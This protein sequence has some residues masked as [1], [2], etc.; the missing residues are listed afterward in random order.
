MESVGI[1]RALWRR[2]LLV[3][4][5]A[6]LA[7]AMA[8]F[9][10]YRVSPASL[11]LQARTASSGYALERVLIDTP[12]SLAADAD[13]KG[14]DSIANRAALLGAL[15]ASDEARATMADKLGLRPSQ[16]A[17]IGAAD[18]LPQVPTPLA[19]KAIEVA[20]PHE[21]YSVVVDADPSLP[22]LS[23]YAAAPDARKAE[24]L[25]DQAIAA[26]HPLAAATLP[27]AGDVK[28]ERLGRVEAGTKT[29]SPSKAKALAVGLMVFLIWCIAIIVLDSLLLRR[30]ALPPLMEARRA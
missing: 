18:A 19:T 8:V 9:A 16:I 26:L 11:S 10:V 7:L 20:K 17:V 23:I 5:G 6:L 14:A 4:L 24:G 2:R 12:T 29:V 15:L 22:I 21:P 3:S 28:I 27:A 13:A 25:A 1:L 30:A